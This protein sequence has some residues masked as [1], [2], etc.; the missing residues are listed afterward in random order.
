MSAYKKDVENIAKDAE[1]NKNK[2]IQRDS[3]F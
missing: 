3:Y 2:K 1:N